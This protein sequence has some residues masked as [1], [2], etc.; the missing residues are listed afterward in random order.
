MTGNSNRTEEAT[1]E[2]LSPVEP[3]GKDTTDQGMRKGSSIYS[4]RFTIHRI[5]DTDPR[6]IESITKESL[7]LWK[8]R[9]KCTN[10]QY[11]RKVKDSIYRLLISTADQ[12]LRI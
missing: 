3:S 12:E 9:R 1:W 6:E 10:F 2:H 5:E 7:E 4:D 11:E 8:R